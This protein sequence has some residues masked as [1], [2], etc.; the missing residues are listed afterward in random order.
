MA[1]S[2]VA[3]TG[4]ELAG[5]VALHGDSPAA[6]NVVAVRSELRNRGVGSA[7]IGAACGELRRRGH[8]EVSAAGGGPYL[9]PGIPRDIPGAV[10]FLTSS[11]WRCHDEVYDLTR[12]LSDFETPR[13]VTERGREAGVVFGQATAPE[14]D[15]VSTVALDHWYPGWDRYFAAAPPEN[16]V[17]GRDRTGEVVAALIIERPGQAQ[18]WEPMLGVNVTTIAC[19]GTMRGYRDRGVGTALVAAASEL[20]RNEPGGTTCHIGWTVLLD[21]YGRLGYR[22]WR[23]Y[24]TATLSI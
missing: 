22:P 4:G 2:L 8:T 15:H 3:F 12:S 10:E 5:T 1:D 17:V 20:L 23:S 6:V 13:A 16:V 24:A 19:V 18:R 14:R 7:L 11:G 21:F 9:W